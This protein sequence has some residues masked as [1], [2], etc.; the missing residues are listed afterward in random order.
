M[1]LRR[2]LLRNR[3]MAAGGSACR[4]PLSVSWENPS[5]RNSVLQLED[6]GPQGHRMA[7][8]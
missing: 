1:L 3:E 4:H 2:Q 8:A 5:W 7:T 6:P